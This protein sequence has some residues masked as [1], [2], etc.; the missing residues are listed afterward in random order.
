LTWFSTGFVR[1]KRLC[2]KAVTTWRADPINAPV[3]YS[4]RIFA[5]AMKMPAG[6]TTGERLSRRCNAVVKLRVFKDLGGGGR[7]TSNA[8]RARTGFRQAGKLI[9]SPA[10]LSFFQLIRPLLQGNTFVHGAVR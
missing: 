7:G 10:F 2:A 4:T 9:E 3:Q 1:T 5:A 6:I 8:A